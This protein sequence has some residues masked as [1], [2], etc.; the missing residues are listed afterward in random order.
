MRT[1][2]GSAGLRTLSGVLALAVLGG[3]FLIRA[4]HPP[5]LHE[6]ATQRSVQ[7]LAGNVEI[8]VDDE[9]ISHIWAGGSEDVVFGLGYIHG[10]ERLFQVDLIRRAATGR[11]SEAFGKDMLVADRRLRL[12]SYRLDEAVAALAPREQKIIAAYCAGIEHAAADMEQPTVEHRILGLAFEPITPR[13]VVA[14]ARLQSWDLSTDFEQELLRAELR[15]ALGDRVGVLAPDM[16]AHGAAIVPADRVPANRPRSAPEPAG[17]KP[18]EAEPAE[19]EPAETEPDATPESQP[20]SAPTARLSPEQA[21][22][23]SLRQVEQ[24]L[25]QRFGIDFSAASNSWVVAPERSQSG[26]ALLEN[27]THLAHRAPGV[28]YLTHLHTPDFEVIG[29]TFP[30][31]PAV[32]IGVTRHLAWGF[33]TSY[34]DVQDVYRLQPA[35][36]RDDAYLLDGEVVPFERWDQTIQIGHGDEAEKMQVP[37]YASRFGPVLNAGREDKLVDTAPHALAW[38][39][40]ES[41]PGHANPIGAFFDLYVARDVAAARR[42]FGRAGSVFQNVVIATRSGDIAYHLIGL[43]PR[44]APTHD[45]DEVQDGST[46]AHLWQGFLD[47]DEKPAA[48]NPPEGFIVAANQRITE[49]PIT[50]HL[51]RFGS[52]PYRALRIRQ[53]VTSKPKLSVRDLRRMQVDVESVQPPAVLAGLLRAW[54]ADSDFRAELET[55]RRRLRSMRAALA[56]WDHRYSIDSVGAT[57]YELVYDALRRASY[58]RWLEGPT[59]EHYLDNHLSKITMDEAFAAMQRGEA[60][61][62][63]EDL[64]QLQELLAQ[65]ADQAGQQLADQL[66]RD[67]QDWTWGRVH[68]LTFGHPFG[69]IWPLDKIFNI[70]P[71]PMFGNWNCVAAESGRPV[72]W[73]ASMRTVVEMGPEPVI[74]MVT[75]TGNAGYALSP[76]Y[77]NMAKRFVRGVSL[78]MELDRDALEKRAAGRLLLTPAKQ[79]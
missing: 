79:D 69:S 36:G 1:G 43:Q 49:G 63:F 7:G 39:G 77:D 33:T 62:L 38:A 66:G 29:Y 74:Y 22:Q 31:L 50:H 17:G 3:C 75:D 61:P 6:Q 55:P 56:S 4:H 28:F 13:D 73:G 71:Y 70:G 2:H 18:T 26:H 58:G 67:P 78:R 15:H 23:L 5:P 20:A 47:E 11:L 76:N 19:T 57:V 45:N 54:P 14:M 40:F 51:G 48:L 64:L 42:A 27:D 34:N 24:L 59:L 53:L 52:F 21:A 10:R 72:N 41:V 37:F 8:I 65:A 16:P 12:L 32:L 30:G 68:T 9:G 35:P 46:T 25:H 44:R 60:N